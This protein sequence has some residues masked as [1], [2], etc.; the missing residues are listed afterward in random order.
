MVNSW[1]VT[2]NVFNVLDTRLPESFGHLLGFWLLE[3]LLKRVFSVLG[4]RRPFRLVAAFLLGDVHV[5]VNVQIATGFSVKS[6]RCRLPADLTQ[7]YEAE[8]HSIGAV[9]WTSLLE[10]HTSS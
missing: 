8:I 6:V 7:R 5:G 10:T 3:H 9:G 1:T 4:I 2:L